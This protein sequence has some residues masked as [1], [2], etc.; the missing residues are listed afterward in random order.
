MFIRCIRIVYD[1]FLLL[2]FML[3]QI[4]FFK[5]NDIISIECE[6]RL[7]IF[8]KESDFNRGICVLVLIF[9]YVYF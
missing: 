4:E 7:E 8:I 1:L 2:W 5:N 6:D 9:K 3:F